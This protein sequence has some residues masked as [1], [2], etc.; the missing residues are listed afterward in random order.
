[1]ERRGKADTSNPVTCEACHGNR[2]HSLDSMAK[3]TPPPGFTRVGLAAIVNN[4]TEKVSCQTCHIP[5]MARG[6][7]PTKLSW[8]WSEAGKMGPDGKPFFVRDE[9]GHVVYDSRKGAFTLGHD[10]IPEYIWFNGVV[11]YTLIG[12]KVERSA[13]PVPINHFEGSATDG[14]SR[15]WPVKVFR[16]VQ[17]YDPV[18]KHLVVIHS[19]G[20]DKDAF[21]TN[22]NW[23]RAVRRGMREF[24]VPFSG[25]VEFIKTEMMWP[26]THMVAPK[27]DTLACKEC[28]DRRGSLAEGRLKNVK[29]L[30]RIPPMDM[31]Y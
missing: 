10:V 17:P 4:H 13:E 1:M 23:E 8:D 2:P 21:F 24:G 3:L 5:A 12:D 7:V 29:G 11:T 20:T 6:G 9:A 28:H 15:I 31:G 26:L 22:F 14:K 25:K 19:Y 16:G 18:N 27:E 30:K